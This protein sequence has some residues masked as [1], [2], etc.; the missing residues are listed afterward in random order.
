VAPT[1]IHFYSGSAMGPGYQ[2]DC[3]VGSLGD[4]DTSIVFGNN[5]WVAT[6][7]ETGPDGALYVLSYGNDQIYRIYDPV[8]I[9][10]GLSN[11][12]LE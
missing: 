3:F 6:D 12:E 5:F 10:V 11:W 8:H 4:T 9:P 7:M 2:Y 1:A